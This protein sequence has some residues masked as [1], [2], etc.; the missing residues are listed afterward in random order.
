MRRSA[1]RRR[2]RPHRTSAPPAPIAVRSVANPPGS[3]RYCR[4]AGAP[5]QPA[6]RLRSRSRAVRTRRAEGVRRPDT[7]TSAP[8]PATRRSA[9]PPAS[10][11]ST[12]QRATG[13]PP[14]AARAIHAGSAVRS[15]RA[16]GDRTPAPR[17]ATRAIRSVEARNIALA[18]VHELVEREEAAHRKRRPPRATAAQNRFHD[19]ARGGGTPGETH[20]TRR[21]GNGFR[22]DAPS[23][24]LPKRVR[25]WRGSPRVLRPPFI[26]PALRDAEDR[27]SP[28]GA[29][30]SDA[31]SGNAGLHLV[32]DRLEPDAAVM[33]LRAPA[34]D[35]RRPSW[36]PRIRWATASARRP[37]APVTRGDVRRRAART[38]SS[39][40]RSSGSAFLT[41]TRPP[42]MPVRSPLALLDLPGLD[43]LLRIVYR[44]E[45]VGLKH[46]QLADPIPADPAGRQIRDATVREA[47]AGIRDI[48]PRLSTGT[49][50]A[51]IEIGSEP[52]QDST[53]SR[54]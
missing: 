43:L 24:A 42:S 33:R 53:T 12:V 40:S 49:P 45:R 47:Q 50:T 39:N 32:A 41:S 22:G 34:T 26:R 8:Q 52:T 27:A 19:A 20:L 35:R 28:T 48:D 11:E 23:P 16:L 36:R 25:R 10:D 21:P 18:Q 3:T 6:G 51:S 7:E 9:S 5:A 17:L 2:R 38:K 15:T 44:D 37:S 29:A 4:P 14:A 31:E 54:S 30:I 46:A 1:R 13:T